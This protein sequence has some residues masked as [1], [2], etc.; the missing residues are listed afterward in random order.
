MRALMRTELDG[1][2]WVEPRSTHLVCNSIDRYSLDMR[3]INITLYKKISISA[4][5]ML[6]LM[7]N[8]F[9]NALTP[10]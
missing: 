7:R 2:G 10:I 9:L 5:H 6:S 4:P 8:F 3:T 1:C